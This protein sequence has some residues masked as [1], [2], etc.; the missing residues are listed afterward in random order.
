MRVTRLQ[1]SHFL[2]TCLHHGTSYSF[3]CVRI[4]ALT[5]FVQSRRYD[6]KPYLRFWPD[7]LDSNRSQLFRSHNNLLAGRSVSSNLF[8]SFFLL[9]LQNQVGCIKVIFSSQLYC[10]VLNIEIINSRIC[11]GSH[12]SRRNRSRCPS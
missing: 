2:F 10:F 4:V 6:S 8:L 5:L 9:S 7:E 12:L 3:V 11:Y 1:Y